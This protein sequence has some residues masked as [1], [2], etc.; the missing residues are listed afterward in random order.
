NIVAYGT[1]R[2]AL[3]L[4]PSIF[5]DHHIYSPLCAALAD[6]FRI[7]LIDGPGHG[8]SEGPAETFSMSDCGQAMGQVIDHYALERPIIGG[9]SWGGMTA[10]ALALARPNLARGL[11]LL[12]TPM[13]LRR[14][15][16]SLATR[17][18]AAGARWMPGARVFRNGVARSFFSDGA[19]ARQPEAL[20]AFHTHLQ[21]A[22]PR[23]LAAAV[24]SVMLRGSPIDEKL[25]QIDLPMLVIAG[26]EDAM[27]PLASQKAAVAKTQ[28]AHLE[29][30]RG[31]HISVLE[32]PQ[33]VARLIANFAQGL[34]AHEKSPA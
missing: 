5:T 18:I 11:V 10:V 23:V 4:W 24:R 22:D 20:R 27:Y 9:T 3:V 19:M 2:R 25:T 34:S 6:R 1:G 17:M 8:L 29:V 26:A 32:D 7:I 30:I 12:N 33:E 14:D 13:T 21:Q 28:Q 15:A 16:P 31:R